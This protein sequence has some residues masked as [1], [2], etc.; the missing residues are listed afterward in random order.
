MNI[1]KVTRGYS[2]KITYDFQSYGFEATIEAIPELEDMNEEEL[3]AFGDK[4]QEAAK[5]MVREDIRRFN[6]INGASV[7]Q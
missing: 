5:A 2:R 1:A 7:A 6:E 3:A 4:V